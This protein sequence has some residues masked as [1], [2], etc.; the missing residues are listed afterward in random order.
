MAA[1]DKSKI[2]ECARCF[3]QVSIEN[4]R[5]DDPACPIRAQQVGAEADTL[6]YPELAKANLLRM[7]AEYKEA[8]E[9]CLSILKRHPENATA[10]TMLG[11]I[12]AEQGDLAQAKDWYSMAIELNP[13]SEPD[14]K[15]LK[16]IESRIKE[17][18]AASTA[19]HLGLPEKRPSYG[20]FIV[21]T[22]LIV[23][24]VG[25]VSFLA[26]NY[27]QKVKTAQKPIVG[28]PIVIQNSNKTNEPVG[29]TGETGQQSPTGGQEQAKDDPKPQEPTNPDGAFLQRV[30]TQCQE[31]NRVLSAMQDPRSKAAV[32]TFAVQ[33]SEDPS[34]IAAT[35]GSSFLAVFVDCPVVMLRAS[36][37]GQLLYCADMRVEDLSSE[38]G[39]E[40]NDPNAPPSMDALK[41]ALTNTWPRTAQDPGQDSLPTTDGKGQ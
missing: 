23:V 18:E 12:C 1:P 28:T 14:Q 36:S 16:A 3:D 7:R 29:T 34:E 4:C 35:L 6:I 27:L 40:Q 32:I 19:Q 9:L 5:C 21:A 39:A 17:R 8:H 2:Q 25:V 33:N 13:D 22:I 30:M 38:K 10:H 11:D 24:V 20:G 15:K 31:G 41:R 26:G 37:G